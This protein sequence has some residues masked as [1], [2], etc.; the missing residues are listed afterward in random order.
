[1]V[2]FLDRSFDALH[3]R[4]EHLLHGTLNWVPV[5]AVFALIVLGSI[6]FLYATAKSELAPPEDQGVIISASQA[7]PNSTLQQRQLYTRVV[8]ETFVK[9]PEPDHVFQLDI[10][11][12]PNAAM[13]SQPGSGRKDTAGHFAL[14]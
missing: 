5:T 2:L 7:A 10:P 13:V 1:L 9:H 3:R 6:Y 4:Y 14:V 8:S 11:G 12:Q